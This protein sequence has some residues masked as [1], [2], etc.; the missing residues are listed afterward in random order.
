VT[1]R[2][3]LLV[4]L[5]AACASGHEAP[6]GRCANCADDAGVVG[7][8][9]LADG[10]VGDGAVGDGAV[11]DGAVG[12]GAVGDG[13]PGTIP[14][15]ACAAT[16][17][18]DGP[19]PTTFDVTSVGTFG[20]PP[21]LLTGDA[22]RVLDAASWMVAAHGTAQTSAAPAAVAGGTM[23]ASQPS[24]SGRAVGLFARGGQ[25]F[26]V[27][28]A[29]MSFGAP[30][31]IPCTAPQPASQCQARAAGDGHLWVRAG[32][33]LYEQVGATFASRGGPPIGIG[34]FDVDVAGDVWIGNGSITAGEVFQI[35]ELVRGAGGWTKTGS[36]TTA[37]LGTAATAI[38]GGFH[39]DSERS[40]FAADGSIHLWS[41][42]RC[43]GTGDRNKL[44]LYV[45]SRDGVTWDVETLPD[46]GTFTD[47]QVTW[48][49][50]AS[51][52]S[53]YDN[54]RF[55]DESS[56]TPIANGDGTWSYPDR[57]LNVIARCL[58]GAGH[59]AF[60]RVAKARLPGWT[61][62]G[63][64]RFSDTGVVTLVTTLGLTQVY[65]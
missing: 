48:K 51:W 64:P 53:D 5:L 55:V 42:A 8:G 47:G 52:A 11:G 12:D 40:T 44:Q 3:L 60:G 26:A 33:T 20:E 34:I 16:S 65:P 63:F 23:F 37:M 14:L 10:A 57:Q 19:L 35:W 36:L 13:N 15:H 45:R 32:Q 38:E 1:A 58:D 6:D 4:T 31:A 18:I 43:I 46:I 24:I 61:V 54:A 25:V 9:R 59:L 27:P 41:D 30:I 22:A 50:L 2:G 21:L 17:E 29:G 62:R 28:F 49:N 56:P 7:D 39:L